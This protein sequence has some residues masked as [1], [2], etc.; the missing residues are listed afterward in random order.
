VTVSDV[1]FE[2]AVKIAFFIFILIASRKFHL[3]DKVKRDDVAEYNAKHKG[4][5]RA[6]A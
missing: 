5:A 4:G 6:K 2:N 3:F 1:V